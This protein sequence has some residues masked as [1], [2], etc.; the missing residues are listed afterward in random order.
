[1]SVDQY[2]YLQPGGRL[3]LNRMSVNKI[4]ITFATIEETIRRVG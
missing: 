3:A 2:I 4:G 1:M